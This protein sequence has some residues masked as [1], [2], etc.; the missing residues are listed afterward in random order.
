VVVYVTDEDDCSDPASDTASSDVVICREG[1]ADADGDLTPDAQRRAPPGP[2]ACF[3]AE[4]GVLEAPKPAIAERCAVSRAANSNCEWHRDRLL[5]V[6]QPARAAARSQ[7]GSRRPGHLELRGRRGPGRRRAGC[8]ASPKA[9]P[10]P[11]AIPSCRST[12]PRRSPSSAAPRACVWAK[13]RPPASSDLGQAFAGHR[14]LELARS[15]PFG[16]APGDARADCGLCGGFDLA[17]PM[18]TLPALAFAT[19]LD[20]RP[21]CRVVEGLGFRDCNAQELE[22][23]A[24][25][26]LRAEVACPDCAEPEGGPRAGPPGVLAGGVRAL[27]AWPDVRAAPRGRGGGSGGDAAH[28][29]LSF[30]VLAE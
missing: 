20:T 5:P 12:I 10:P 8:C 3:Q 26:L 25:Y 24:N 6:Q 22:N 4:C 23:T 18:A 29:P 17:P 9:C 7:R 27:R 28:G 1:P 19:C 16:C 11:S 21:G 30:R 14:Y 13:S 15:V 2:R